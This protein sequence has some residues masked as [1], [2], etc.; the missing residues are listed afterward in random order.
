[1]DGAAI[2][3]HRY[4]PGTRTNTAKKTK[5]SPPRSGVLHADANVSH[6]DVSKRLESVSYC[7]KIYTMEGIE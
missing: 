3:Q 6:N 4:R 1:M 5:G 7:I 2:F